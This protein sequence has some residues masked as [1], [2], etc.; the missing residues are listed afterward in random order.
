[1]SQCQ[2]CHRPVTTHPAL[3]ARYCRHHQVGQPAANTTRN[4]FHHAIKLKLIGAGT[5]ARVTRCQLTNGNI[6]AIKQPD[7]AKEYTDGLTPATLREIT[8]LWLMRGNEHMIQLLG[9]QSVHDPFKGK[10]RIQLMLSHHTGDL[11]Q[12]IRDVPP[13]DRVKHLED[14]M[15]QLL[16]GLAHLY[17]YGILHRD[18][19]PANI[20][21]DYQLQLQSGLTDP[22]RLVGAPKYRYADFGLAIQLPRTG[23]R[24]NTVMISSVYTLSYRP[25]EIAIIN[26]DQVDIVYDDRADMWA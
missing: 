22:P 20:L 12:F 1:M 3:D 13:S 4:S 17:R 6:V 18:I 14:T 2:D 10:T 19:K 25:P 11:D 21:V 15:T 7:P 8:I 26:D 24:G 16:N 5:Y 9:V 23:D